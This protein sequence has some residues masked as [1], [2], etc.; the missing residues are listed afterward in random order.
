MAHF[1]LLFLKLWA[2]EDW[3][4]L[5]KIEAGWSSLEDP[6][7]TSQREPYLCP[8]SMSCSLL[9][10]MTAVDC[11]VHTKW[12]RSTAIPFVPVIPPL[13]EIYEEQG[14]GSCMDLRRCL[15]GALHTLADVQA[16][17]PFNTCFVILPRPFSRNDRS[18]RYAT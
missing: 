4:R 8:S 3:F 12:H 11:I 2:I 13:D 15:D 6:S 16:S 18:Q 17:R 7:A 14:N 5:S 1:S 10:T 9:F